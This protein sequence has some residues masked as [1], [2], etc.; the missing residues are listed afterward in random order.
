MT[1]ESEEDTAEKIV[2]QFPNP[3]SGKTYITTTPDATSV[4]VHTET[5]EGVYSAFEYEY[6]ID[7]IAWETENGV[8]RNSS[9]LDEVDEDAS[10]IISV[11]FEIPKEDVDFF[12][13]DENDTT[14]SDS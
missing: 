2:N 9:S 4:R 3:F 6:E 13:R 10:N 7:R 14:D 1:E 5:E 11:V 12:N 8:S